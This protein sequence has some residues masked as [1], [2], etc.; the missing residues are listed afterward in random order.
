MAGHKNLILYMPGMRPKPPAAIHRDNLWRCLL[1][2]IRRAAPDIAAEMADHGDCFEL[3]PWPHLFYRNPAD[4]AEDAAGLARLLA[5]AGPEPRDIEEARHWHRR[6]ARLAYLVGDAFPVLIDWIADPRMKDT[7]KDALRYFGND[8]GVAEPIRELVGETLAR[9]VAEGRR[10]LVIAHSLG[11]VVTFDVLWLM[12][13]HERHPLR[14]DT[15]MTIGS[16]LGLNFVRHRLLS[17]G[18][19]GARRFPDNIRRW[20]NLAAVGDM[21]ALGRSFA[22]DF[23]EMLDLG[24]VERIVDETTLYNWFRGPHGLNVH[25]CYSYMANPRVAAVTADWWARG[26]AAPDQPELAAPL[27][28]AGRDR[29]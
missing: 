21:T 25:K 27:A 20:Y 15:L 1:T 4:P 26:A 9:A 7:M 19:E 6:L 24:L 14:V 13:R 22:D 17:A 29:R 8:R 28:G 2:A 23:R 12:S 11:S 3:V 10:L 18:A 16:P 5:Q